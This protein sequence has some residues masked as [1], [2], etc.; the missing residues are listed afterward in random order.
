[1]QSLVESAIVLFDYAYLVYS[2]K[3]VCPVSLVTTNS[4][5]GDRY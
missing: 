1:M 2:N 5:L 4:N 3:P